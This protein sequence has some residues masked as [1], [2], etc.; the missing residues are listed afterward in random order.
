[1]AG[2]AVGTPGIDAD[3]WAWGCLV[4]LACGWSDRLLEADAEA[5]AEGE[6]E[7]G[8]EADAEA[9]AEPEPDGIPGM[10]ADPG[11]DPDPDP[12]FPLPAVEDE[13]DAAATV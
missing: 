2:V 12:A 13:S 5:E 11:A 10:A 8:R 4:L 9:E 7:A 3:G 6:A 1:V